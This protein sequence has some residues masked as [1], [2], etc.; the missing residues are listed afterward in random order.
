RS[1]AAIT[2]ISSTLRPIASQ[3]DQFSS[4][5]LAALVALSWASW[6]EGTTGVVSEGEGDGVEPAANRTAD[7]DTAGTSRCGFC[8]LG[9]A[10][11]GPAVQGH[12]MV[13]GRGR[14]TTLTVHCVWIV[15]VFGGEALL[16]WG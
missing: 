4:T 12:G 9:T 2:R 7:R 15:L 16:T 11:G 8:P 3:V 6:S 14:L 5:Q 13:T 10:V 1:T